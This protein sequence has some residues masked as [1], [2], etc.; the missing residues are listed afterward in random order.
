MLALFGLALLYTSVKVCVAQF[1][2][3]MHILKLFVAFIFKM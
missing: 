2:R 1:K 3:P